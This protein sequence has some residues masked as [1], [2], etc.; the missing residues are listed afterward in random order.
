MKVWVGVF[1]LSIGYCFVDLN[2]QEK[3][4]VEDSLTWRDITRCTSYGIGSGKLYDTYLS[5]QDALSKEGTGILLASCLPGNLRNRLFFRDTSLMPTI[6]LKR[7]PTW[8]SMHNGSI[9]FI[10]IC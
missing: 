7:I 3:V 9:F 8:L 1:L 6:A 4:V 10:A 5:P 2:A